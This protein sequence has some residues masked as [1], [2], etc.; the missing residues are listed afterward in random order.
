MDG[1]RFDALTRTLGS[2]ADRRTTVRALSGAAFGASALSAGAADAKKRKKKC[3]KA[4]RRPNKK[5]K[6]CC[7]GLVRDGSGACARRCTP[8]TCASTSVC[9]GGVCQSCDV[10]ES[11]CFFGALQAA[12]DSAAPGEAIR[13]CAGIYP[14]DIVINQSVRL[15]GAGDGLGAG[16]TVL[17]GSGGG[18]VVAISPGRTVDLQDLRIAGG[19]GANGGGINSNRATLT[20]TDCTVT[21][22]TVSGSGG[23]IFN[24]GGTVVLNTS[25]VTGNDAGVCGGGIYNQNNVGGAAA[26]LDASSVTG[27]TAGVANCGGGIFNETE[28]TVDLVNASSVDDNFAN[29]VENN[30]AGSGA[31]D[32]SGCA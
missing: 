9:V 12:V 8:A 11:G 14:G 30:C 26:T 16:N 4:G 27:N 24:N 1:T 23:G 28:S 3:A 17:D 32:G 21:G 2:L 15:I 25:A 7:P 20:L 10:C 19:G 29:D 13:I 6:R 18:P 22:N 5:R 31:Y